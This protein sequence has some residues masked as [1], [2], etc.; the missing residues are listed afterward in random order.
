VVEHNAPPKLKVVSSEETEL[1]RPINQEREQRNRHALWF[2]I[3]LVGGMVTAALVVM[4]IINVVVVKAA[5]P[6]SNFLKEAK[7]EIVAEVGK[8]VRDNIPQ[9]QKVVVEAKL[10]SESAA[11][12]QT[13]VQREVQAAGLVIARDSPF[14]KKLEAE[15]SAKQRMIDDLSRAK[16]Q[17][18]AKLQKVSAEKAE[19]VDQ[20][21]IVQQKLEKA[22]DTDRSAIV[23]DAVAHLSRDD[24]E[25]LLILEKLSVRES[26]GN[27][28]AYGPWVVLRDGYG[29]P[30]KGPHNPWIKVVRGVPHDRAYGFAQIM[31]ENIPSWSEEATGIRY[32][33]E[34]LVKEPDTYRK[35]ALFQIRKLL[36]KYDH[37]PDDVLSVWHSGRR[38]KQ[39]ANSRDVNLSTPEYVKSVKSA[40]TTDK[41]VWRNARKN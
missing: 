31:G 25:A 32:T 36:Q 2:F 7:S 27:V 8:V 3:K 37:N 17:T 34:Q 24:V 15:N 19:L 41:W 1:G 20:L 30:K 38:L 6:S 18:E 21:D 16:R 26:S 9:Q 5:L 23:K 39:A 35:V 28:R 12:I 13:A 33:P 22:S 11:I 40:S 4:T 10:D 29:K 14:V